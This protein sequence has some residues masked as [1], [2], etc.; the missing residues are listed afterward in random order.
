MDEPGGR[1]LLTFDFDG[2]LCRPP[3]GINPGKGMG[4]S[5]EG[6]GTKGLLWRSEGFRYLGRRPMP[7]A[8]EGF[9]VLAAEHECHVLTARAEQ[10]RG[11]TERWMR[12]YLG[13]V[14]MLHMRPHWRETSAQ[15]KARMLLELRP[16][17]HFEDDPHTAE[18]ASELV[19]AVF[20]VDWGRNRWLSGERI[21]RIGRL[22]EAVP[23]VR[24]LVRTRAGASPQD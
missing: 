19:P 8:A 2:V 6:A 23:I 16:L 12:R 9:R 22:D 4:K 11:L 18:W 14:P 7:G 1:A 17:A 10:A 3:L 13:V 24:E 15:F 21:H 20:L 5:R